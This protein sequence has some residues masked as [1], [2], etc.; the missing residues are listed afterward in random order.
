[1]GHFSNIMSALELISIQCL[2]HDISFDFRNGCR[3]IYVK[4]LLLSSEVQGK[5]D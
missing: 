5:E 2:K 3:N 1:M 4:H